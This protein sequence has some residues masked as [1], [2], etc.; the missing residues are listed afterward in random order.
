MKDF[1]DK[2]AVI[3]GAAS[4]IGLGIAKRCVH[5]GMRLVIADVEQTALDRA[6]KELSAM[7]GTVLPVLTDVSKLSQV[8]TLAKKTVEAF[9]AVHL[10]CNNAGVSGREGSIWENSQADWEWVVGVN[11]WGV[12]HGLRVFIP[13]MLSQNT[14]CHVVNTASTAGLLPYHP[15]ATY[16]VTKHAV[17]A[18]SEHLYRSLA[19]KGAKI[20]ASVLCPG[21]VKTRILSSQR[22]FPLEYQAGP[23]ATPISPEAEEAAWN[24]LIKN[25]FKVLSPDEVADIVFTTIKEEKFYILT[26]PEFNEMVKRRMENIIQG[27][28]PPLGPVSFQD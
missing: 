28:N 21:F 7:G 10:L 4:G 5:E 20:K 6:E 9:G 1:K 18:L 13:V 27:Q 11:F 2:V 17:V 14:E 3:T 19:E 24:F 8:E 16:H 12:I 22:N 25:G 26:H 15:G 23:V